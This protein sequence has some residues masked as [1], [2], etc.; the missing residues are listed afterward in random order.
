MDPAPRKNNGPVSPKS[1][2]PSTYCKRDFMQDWSLD[3]HNLRINIPARSAPA[4]SLSS[5]YLS[6]HNPATGYFFS[7]KS[8]VPHGCSTFKAQSLTLPKSL[9]HLSPLQSPTSKTPSPTPKTPSGTASWYQH[10]SLSEN[11]AHPLPLPPSTSNI[12]HAAERQNMASMTGQWQKGKLIGRGTFGSVYVATN[13]ETGALCAVKE[14]DLIMD[15]PKSAESVKQL[16]QEIRV[17]RQF[18]HPNIVQ[19]YG[20]EI[21]DDHFYIYL[22]YVYPGSI[23]K[24]VR[25]HCGTMTESVVRNFTRHILSGLAYLHSNCTIHRDIKGANLLVDANG[26]VKL[27][28][29]GMAKHLSGQVSILSLKGS[30]YWMAPEILQGSITKGKTNSEV[31]FA[32]DIW[33]VGCT[34][35]E[36]LN[37]MP[38]WGELEGPQAMFKVLN[39]SPPIPEKLSSEGKDFLQLCFQR[40]PAQRPSAEKLL[41]HPFLRNSHDQNGSSFRPLCQLK[42]LARR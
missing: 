18:K 35:I 30:P 7:C 5:P 1:A 15:D 10:K 31:A 20:S 12:S 8:T 4:S 37:G 36:M 38:P 41:Q 2:K 13:R 19:Y 33:S 24:Y 32:V 14:V 40:N 21:V 9:G 34:I 11:Y 26:V 28:D 3:N 6:P 22:E 29:F 27:A 17:L 16:E 39:R 42:W 25:E 23:N